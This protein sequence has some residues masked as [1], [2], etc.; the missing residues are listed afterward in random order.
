MRRKMQMKIDLKL[1]SFVQ[2]HKVLRFLHAT[3]HKYLGFKESNSNLNE[4][5]EEGKD[6][7]MKRI[8]AMDFNNE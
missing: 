3:T 1:S 4:E 5:V 6:I 8:E 2:Y 7:I